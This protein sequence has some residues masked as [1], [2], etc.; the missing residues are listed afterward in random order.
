MTR[1]FMYALCFLISAQAWASTSRSCNFL[2][3]V[4]NSNSH[5][6]V[7]RIE[8]RQFSTW[9]FGPKVCDH[10]V[11]KHFSIKVTSGENLPNMR[12]SSGLFDLETYLICPDESDGCFFDW[13]SHHLDE[14][15]NL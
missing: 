1:Y 11:G 13:E 3:E 7:L 4:V 8:R 15:K 5:E 9:L 14:V 12:S 2:A 6:F 10:A